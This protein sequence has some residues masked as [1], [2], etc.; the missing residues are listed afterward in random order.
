MI[1]K[2]MKISSE[3]SYG[4]DHLIEIHYW[5]RHRRCRHHHQFYYCYYYC[6]C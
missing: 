2:E 6:S 3:S 1:N 4:R 5:W